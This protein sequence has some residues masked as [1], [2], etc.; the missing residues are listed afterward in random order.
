[1]ESRINASLTIITAFSEAKTGNVCLSSGVW[2][3]DLNTLISTCSGYSLGHRSDTCENFMNYICKIH[4]KSFANE[5]SYVH[6]FFNLEMSAS[7]NV[8]P[9]ITTFYYTK[10]KLHKYL[11]LLVNFFLSSCLDIIQLQVRQNMF[12]RFTY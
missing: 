10:I 11:M 4:I 1:M 2:L 5:A 7:K 3:S 8:W 6:A 12:T 9:K